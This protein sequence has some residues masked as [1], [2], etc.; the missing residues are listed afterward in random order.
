MPLTRS[1]TQLLIAALPG[2][3]RAA[4]PL[5]GVIEFHPQGGDV[6]ELRIGMAETLQACTLGAADTGGVDAQ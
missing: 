5:D 4:F 3:A 2:D 1:A 6:P